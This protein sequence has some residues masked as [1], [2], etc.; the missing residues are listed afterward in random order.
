VGALFG[1]LVEYFHKKTDRVRVDNV[2]I[3]EV[4]DNPVRI[5]LKQVIEGCS[6]VAQSAAKQLSL[7]PDNF[8]TISRFLFGDAHIPHF[9]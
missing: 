6:K 4:Q 7:H 1:E 9:R 8:Y 5:R 3:L 2:Y